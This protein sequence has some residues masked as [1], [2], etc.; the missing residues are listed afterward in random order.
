[1]TT[2]LVLSRLQAIATADPRELTELH[3]GCCRYCW[4]T[5]NLFQRTPRE[6]REDAYPVDGG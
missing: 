4:G 2:E 5:G 3:R 6:L 1:V